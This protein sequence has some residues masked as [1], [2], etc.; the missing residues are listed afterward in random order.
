[1]RHAANR[2]RRQEPVARS[3]GAKNLLGIVRPLHR[4]D[5]LLPVSDRGDRDRSIRNHGRQSSVLIIDAAG[6]PR[7]AERVVLKIA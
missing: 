3:L 7:D 6:R 4:D 5:P 1:M 2:G